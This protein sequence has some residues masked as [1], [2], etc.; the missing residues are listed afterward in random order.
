MDKVEYLE[1]GV[2]F[3]NQLTGSIVELRIETK[4]LED[5]TW[6]ATGIAAFK[7]TRDGLHWGTVETS[8]SSYDIDPN[9]AA[10]TIM[11][12]LMNTVNSKEFDVALEASVNESE[13]HE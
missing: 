1:E 5:K 6:L 2:D 12:A 10:A 13:K 8:I 7:S 11:M 9:S 3:F 4:L